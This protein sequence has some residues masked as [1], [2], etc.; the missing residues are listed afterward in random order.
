M[1]EK[2]CLFFCVLLLVC[3]GCNNHS[4]IAHTQST[5]QT[6]LDPSYILPKPTLVEMGTGELGLDKGVYIVPAIQSSDVIVG[7][8]ERFISRM[9][10]VGISTSDPGGIPV[11]IKTTRPQLS[12]LIVSTDES[13]DLVINSKGILIEASHYTGVI[14]GLQ[15]L[16]QILHNLDSSLPIMTIRD[17]PRYP[18]RGLMIDVARHWISKETILTNLDAMEASKLNVLHLHLSDDQ[19]FRVES[20]TFKNLHLKGSN[21]QY[22]SHEDIGEIIEAATLR[23][24]RVIPEFDMPG[25]VTSL[26]TAY[27][28][29]ATI[30][31]DYDLMQTYGIHPN[32]LDPTSA[33]TYA[34]INDLIGEMSTLFPDQYIHIGGDEVIL[35]QWEESEKVKTF[36]RNN[37][38]SDPQQLLSYFFLK[39]EQIIKGHGKKM[40]TWNEGIRSQMDPE[41]T[42][43]QA[44]QNHAA[45]F[46]IVRS[47][48]KGIL[49]SG[50]YL[51]HNLSS[52]DL[53]MVDPIS[54]PSYVEI[55]PD[56]DQWEAWELTIDMRGQPT[57]GA[58]Y[59]FGKGYMRTGAMRMI[60]RTIVVP[61]IKTT[62]DIMEF[63]INAGLGLMNVQLDTKQKGKLTGTMSMAPF[64]L[65]VEGE[66]VG[67]HDMDEGIALP[68]FENQKPLVG[69]ELKNVLGGEACMWTDW[70]ND[71]NLISKVWPRAGAVAEKLWSPSATTE[72]LGGFASR[73]ETFGDYLITTGINYESNIDALV[74]LTSDGPDR[75]HMYTFI[76][77]LEEV[78]YYDRFSASLDHNINAP[79]DQLADIVLP[80]S[81]ASV[82]FGTLVDRLQ[83][84]G[85]SP[86]LSD[87]LRGYLDTWIPL[88]RQ[89]EP[90]F[91]RH[92]KIKNVEVLALALSDL[93]KIAAHVMDSR[94]LTAE[95]DRYYGQ[96]KLNAQRKIDGVLLAPAEHLIRLIDSYRKEL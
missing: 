50:W 86:S 87:E 82:R 58:L 56:P 90:A 21:G 11:E 41:V 83:D 29:L 80:E 65:S 45:L 55:V 31:Q 78:K 49:S 39:V 14:H 24:I 10:L 28:E 48:F 59:V 88:Y 1:P 96:L 20:K 68:S 91:A 35:T 71:Q 22:Y 67:G 43:G 92:P 70:T 57:T 40:I 81:M 27:P 33:V 63:K 6:S 5:S 34:F 2:L 54:D 25:H 30:A 12:D 38:L 75:G 36:M 13:Y 93:S 73:L 52:A 44:W 64:N 4:A 95:E 51:N 62:G 74:S 76:H 7:A 72:E 9:K 53:Y 18:W 32:V 47:G 16:S 60:N 77:T 42:I 8:V 17:E 84:Q 79:L 3:T 61:S 85:V 66:Q 15:S 26:L 19:A 37:D 94:T 46:G 69:G 23:G 89:V